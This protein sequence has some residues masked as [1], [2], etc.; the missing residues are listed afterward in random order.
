MEKYVLK[1][2][3]TLL[4]ERI[5]Y[6]RS[7]SIGVWVKAGSILESPCENGLSHF[8]E[9]MAF[10]G[11]LKRSARQISEEMDAV[12]G[13][14]NAATSKLCTNYYAKVIDEDLP[15]AVDILADIACNPALDPAET[16][17]EIPWA[18]PGP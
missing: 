18:C 14:L 5:P 9:H 15:L 10:K 13:H 1:N 8:M 17:K 3:L 6:L 7:A 2:G 11:T 12:G 16:E 4:V